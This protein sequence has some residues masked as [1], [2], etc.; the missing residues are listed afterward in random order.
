MADT[1]EFRI[2]TDEFRTLPVPYSGSGIDK[3]KLSHCFV[4]VGSLPDELKEWMEVNPRIPRFNRKEKLTGVVAKSI[5]QTLMEE[6]EKFALKNQG[7]Y[8][9]VE[10]AE[11][12]K[13]QGGQGWL[14]IR[15]SDPQCHGLVNGGHTFRAIREVALD[16]ECPDPW[17]AYVRLHILESG[18][19]E[20]AL[21]AD[22]AEGLNRS[23]QVDNPSLENLRGTFDKIKAQ[24]EGKLGAEQ[25]SYRQGDSGEIDVQQVIT[26]LG[27]L[28][29]DKFPDRKS[30][31]NSLFGQPKMVLEMFIEDSQKNQ[32]SFDIL[33]PK[34]HEILV[35][36]DKIQQFSAPKLGQL[37]V[38]S[39][40]KDNRVGSKRHKDKPAYFSGSKIG[41]NVPLGYIY[42]MLAAFRANIS[43][44]AWQERRLE[45]RMSPFELLEKTVDEM[46]Q[47][48][49]QEHA[50][51]KGKPAEVGK[52]EA[53]YR[54]CYTVLTLELAQRGLI[55]ALSS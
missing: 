47:I 2:P 12:Q 14:N 9:I 30:H 10:H 11:Y 25:I 8:I 4:K 34:I 20:P 38:S 29:L 42:P 7:I 44:T 40:K 46:T 33:L 35:L 5:V 27:I 1:F 37:R 21:I 15:L 49:K 3:L 48:I 51:N 18:H 55:D 50:D 45:W 53:A 41:G 39:A 23:L 16:S 19:A 22:M 43:H 26:Y 36:T 24:L 17:D 28:N 31:P 13:E 52:K 6:P 54:G 32:P